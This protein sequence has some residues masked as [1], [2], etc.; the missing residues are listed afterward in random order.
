[1]S[2]CINYNLHHTK[3]IELA[4]INNYYIVLLIY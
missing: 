2:H 4:K 3:R 1:M